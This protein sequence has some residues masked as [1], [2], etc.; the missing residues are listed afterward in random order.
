M[1]LSGDPLFTD[2]DTAASTSNTAIHEDDSEVVAMIKELLET[3]I[4]PAVQEDGGD[5]QFQACARPLLVGML[6]LNADGVIVP[7]LLAGL[8]CLKCIK[9]ELHVGAQASYGK[10]MENARTFSFPR[11][12]ASCEVKLSCWQRPALALHAR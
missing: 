7:V 9:P 6:N 5:I 11:F 8:A 12:L 3:R 4:R 2:A 10:L 1:P